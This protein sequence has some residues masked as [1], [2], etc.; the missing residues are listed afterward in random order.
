MNKRLLVG[1]FSAFMAMAPW[2]GNALET[3]NIDAPHLNLTDGCENCHFAGLEPGDC[4]VRCHTSNV[5][6]YADT[7][8]PVAVTHQGLAC[9]AC[10]NPHV[11]L[12]TGGITGSFTGANAYTGGLP[13]DPG[14]NPN[15]GTTTLTGVTPTPDASWAAKTSAERGMILWVNNGETNLD[16]Q[17]QT[18]IGKSSF[19]VKA[20]AGDTVTVRGDMSAITP[21]SFELRRGQLIAKAV[22]KTVGESYKQGT[23]AVQFPA[24]VAQPFVDTTNNNGICQVCHT[25]Y[26]AQTN[27]TGTT[28]WSN[29]GAGAD[30]NPTQ[31]CTS[32]H[33][34]DS[35]F[36]VTGCNACHQ[37]V[38]DDGVPVAYP[39]QMAV[40]STGSLTAGQHQLHAVDYA[41]PC[42]TCHVGTG[43]DRV[44]DPLHPI[45][46]GKIQIGFNIGKYMGYLTS[47]GGQTGVAYEGTN[48][49]KVPYGAPM[50]CGTVYCHSNGKPVRL[51]CNTSTTNT[52]PKWDGS[53]IA[54]SDPQADGVKCNNC[55]GF[56][57]ATGAQN[58]IT[59]GAHQKHVNSYLKIA[60]YVCHADT[61]QQVGGGTPTNYNGQSELLPNK[62]K[63]ANAAYDIKGSGVY[64]GNAVVLDST[65]P[66]GAA[67][68][69]DPVAKT[70]ITACHTP[71]NRTTANVWTATDTE[72]CPNACNDLDGVPVKNADPVIL[73]YANP[74]DPINTADVSQAFVYANDPN[75][76]HLKIKSYDTD[77]MDVVMNQCRK[78][79]DPT[80][81]TKGGHYNQAG[82]I[83]TIMGGD[84][85]N[86]FVYDAVFPNTGSSDKELTCRFSDT[87]LTATGGKMCWTYALADNDP[88][89]YATLAANNWVAPVAN[90]NDGLKAPYS[91]GVNPVDWACIN[92]TTN[93]A[94]VINDPMNNIKP[95]V[96]KSVSV[97]GKRVSL[98]LTVNDPDQIDSTKQ[99][100]WAAKFGRSGGHA[101]NTNHYVQI[102]WAGEALTK[103]TGAN[104]VPS[105][106]EAL[107]MSAT[108]GSKTYF[109]DFDTYAGTNDSTTTTVANANAGTGK[110]KT[111]VWIQAYICDNHMAGTDLQMEKDCQSYG[112]FNVVFN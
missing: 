109:Y 69:W 13:T 54:T 93:S 108:G 23:I 107:P 11:S 38:G 94:V 95:E 61:A 101:A 34:H 57:N 47:Y 58:I 52:T 90:V 92:P 76:L 20:I 24:S 43:M 86:T 49:T 104:A 26:D 35:G 16:A 83:R 96:T 110:L 98:T 41:Y 50:T 17:G 48:H 4:T 2:C 91:A 60:C 59:S 42:A 22:T 99:A 77:N 75:T 25:A 1:L 51:N 15:T 78:G 65:L 10:H 40:P 45:A 97:T 112:W 46:D 81:P 21:G 79:S 39:A 73:P 74:M 102:N 19:E 56:Q 36:L 55:H 32:C 84:Q 14:Y 105:N 37:G 7:V 30:H 111:N 67:G 103:E 5:P 72:T 31:A 70:C 87:K 9:Q 33:R 8:A 88:T 82:F 18:V 100:Y 3:Q 44:N 71:A 62:T 106:A 64:N 80:A 66:A 89:S 85:C 68:K 29:D 63:H 12:Q 27:P 28:H 6:P 53:D